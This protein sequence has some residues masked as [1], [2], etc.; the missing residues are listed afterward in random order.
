METVLA[1]E[2]T[3]HYR[4]YQVLARLSLELKGDEPAF[5]GLRQSMEEEVERIFGLLGLLAPGEDLVSAWQAL[6]SPAGPAHANALELLENVL[7]PPLRRLVLP[8]VD[9]HVSVVERAA[10]ATRFV[11]ASVETREEAV[12]TLAASDDAW[13][14]SCAARIVGTLRLRGFEAELDRWL[15]DPDPLLREAARAA[16]LQFREEPSAEPEARSDAWGDTTGR[17]GVG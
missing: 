5:F 10:L 16:R 1:A 9:G 2:I 17:L 15:E 3:G 8:L 12:A 6:H 4:S 7:K 14:R 13:L 11:G